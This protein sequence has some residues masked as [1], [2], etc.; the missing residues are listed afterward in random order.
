MERAFSKKNTAIFH[1][2]AFTGAHKSFLKVKISPRQ[3]ASHMAGIRHYTKTLEKDESEKETVSSSKTDAKTD[4]QKTDKTSGGDTQFHEFYLNK[5]F[6]TTKEALE[7]FINDPLLYE[8]G[9][10]QWSPLLDHMNQVF[11]FLCPLQAKRTTTRPM[12][13]RC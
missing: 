11:H 1:S 7:V 3:L 2:T 4:K 13:S 12:G 10:R 9:N 5:N 6:K 8:P